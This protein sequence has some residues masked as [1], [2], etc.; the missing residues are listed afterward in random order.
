MYQEGEQLLS[1][2]MESLIHL[3]FITYHVLSFWDPGAL[4]HKEEKDP[5]CAPG[6]QKPLKH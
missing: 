1:I 6:K 4:T 2:S 3:L 5:C